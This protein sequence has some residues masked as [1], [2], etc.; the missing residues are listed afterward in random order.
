MSLLNDDDEI[1]GTPAY[2]APEQVEGGP[3]TPATDIYAFGVVLFEMV[4]G[5]WPFMAETPLRTAVKRLQ[6]PP[7]SP[8]I[9]VPD[10][11]PRWEATILRCLARAPADRFASV[12]E[13]VAALE[14]TAP[15]STAARGERRR[16]RLAA[17]SW[18]AR[19]SLSAALAAP[20]S[21]YRRFARRAHGGITSLAVLPFANTSNDPEQ[22]YLS[23][24]ISESLINRLSQLPGLKVVANSSSSRYKGKDADPREVARA[25]DVPACSTGRVLQRGDDLSISVELIDGRDRTQVWGEQYSPQGAPTCSQ[26]QGEISREIA[27]KLQLRL[28]AGAA[29]AAGHAGDRNPEAYEL[30]LKGHFHRAKGRAEDRKKAGEYFQRGHRRRSRLRARPCR[31]VRHLPEPGRQQ[32]GR[33]RPSTCPRREAAARKALELDESL[34]EAHYALANLMTYA[35]QWADAER[36]YKRAIELNPNLALAHRWYASVS[37]ALGPPRR[38][39]R[40]DHARPRARSAVA[41]RQRHGGLR[42]CV[43]ASIRAGDRER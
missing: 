23:D 3:V 13:V 19:C 14:G 28:T 38:G 29:A 1:S 40:R 12:G 33:L 4:T 26:V 27:E 20:T 16:W 5:T 30:L 7:P 36:E 18:R 21:C 10:L 31:S 35:W 22:E 8:R 39:H 34:A 2:M 42:P 15:P 41:G 25:L 9:H 6:E 17:A 37:A 11:D 43:G 24:G 32:P